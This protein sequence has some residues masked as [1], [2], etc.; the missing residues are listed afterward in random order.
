[1]F[2]PLEE[3]R[4]PEAGEVRDLRISLNAPVL[5]G[6]RSAEAEA[7]PLSDPTRAALGW[8]PAEGEVSLVRLWLRSESGAEAVRAFEF[9]QRPVGPAARARALEAAE[10]YLAGL[11][12]LFPDAEAAAA[13]A[14]LDA[15]FVPIRPMGVP[16][17]PM[18]VPEPPAGPPAA[19]ASPAPG[20]EPRAPRPPAASSPDRR[21]IR[22]DGPLAKFRARP[23]AD[24]APGPRRSPRLLDRLARSLG[25][26]SADPGGVQS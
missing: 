25:F 16:E 22:S 3:A 26:K 15:A 10:N 7:R 9:R 18:G 20:T 5:L 8:L 19:N 13:A 23:G 2:V 21:A 1:M 24:A 12:F 6:T 4:W 17:R 11:G 14:K